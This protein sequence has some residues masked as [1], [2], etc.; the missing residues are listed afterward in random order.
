MSSQPRT[1]AGEEERRLNI[2]TLVIA[3][4]A[5]AAAAVVTSQFWIQGTWMAAAVTPVI[6]A[7]VSELLHRPA[8]AIAER[9]TSRGVNVIPEGE[10][11]H[12]GPAGGRQR[13]ERR[14]ELGSR[15]EFGSRSEPGRRSE[16]G[17][18]APSAVAPVRVYRSQ[19][20]GRPAKPANGG[21]A[22]ASRPRT[23][24]R[25]IAIGVVALT[26]VLAFAITALAMTGTELL[27]GGSI[28]KDSGGTTLFGGGSDKSDQPS[29]E[30]EQQDPQ[31]SQPQEGETGSG[32]DQ[33]QPQPTEPSEEPPPESQPEPE[34]APQAPR[35][36][37]QQPQQ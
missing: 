23:R 22:R 1:A 3:S 5:S 18:R 28:G 20:G 10:Q 29:G 14:S 6:V 24:R 32:G 27:T 21:P 33:E 2:G 13:A 17:S 9:V 15:R 7:L 36:A 11:G 4:I 19:G 26:A 12:P 30:Q 16:S 35:V 34:P 37:P 31:E 8:G 25:R